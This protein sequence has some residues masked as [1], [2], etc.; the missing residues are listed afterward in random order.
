MLP[1]SSPTNTVPSQVIGEDVTASRVGC[2]LMMMLLTMMMPLTVPGDSRFSNR[3]HPVL[4]ASKWDWV[5]SVRTRYDAAEV[6][7][8]VSPRAVTVWSPGPADAG[9]SMVILMLAS[10]P[11][12]IVVPAVV[13][14]KWTVTTSSLRKPVPETS[15]VVVGGPTV[16]ARTS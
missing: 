4:A 8:L 13:S 5:Q 3:F 2:P 9:T 11:R 1:A 6:T 14:S 12:A 15:T 16:D 7:P 10:R